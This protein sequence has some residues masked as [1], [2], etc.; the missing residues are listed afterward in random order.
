M[1]RLFGADHRVLVLTIA[2]MG[3]AAS[4]GFLLIA[5]PL[6]IASEVVSGFS[7]ELTTAF[8]SGIIVSV[9]TLFTIVPQPFA[10]YLSDTIGRRKPFAVASLAVRSVTSLLFTVATIYPFVLLVN[11][12]T[13]A[14]SAVFTPAAMALITEYSDPETRA[15]N[16]G[17]YTSLRFVGGVVGPLTAGGLI[18]SGPFKIAFLGTVTGFEAAFLCRGAR[19]HR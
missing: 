11:V 19:H 1:A 8:I 7:F 5:L 14:A 12:V 4:S 2:Q 18:A 10:G 16:F 9:G 3:E 17:A 13:M 15:V 6:Y